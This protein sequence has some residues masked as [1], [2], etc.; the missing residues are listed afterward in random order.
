MITVVLIV[1]RESGFV[2]FIAM[3]IQRFITRAI[4]GSYKGPGVFVHYWDGCY[5]EDLDPYLT[6]K[7][8]FWIYT[9]DSENEDS[10]T[11]PD[12]DSEDGLAW[13]FTPV[14]MFAKG[15]PIGRDYFENRS[16]FIGMGN[17]FTFNDVL[18]EFPNQIPK[19]APRLERIDRSVI[20]RICPW[21]GMTAVRRYNFHREDFFEISEEPYELE[22]VNPV[23]WTDGAWS[24]GGYDEDNT[25]VLGNQ[26]GDCVVCCPACQALF[27]ASDVEPKSG[28]HDSSQN[29]AL[30]FVAPG[31]YS[32]GHFRGSLSEDWILTAQLDQ[33]MDYLEQSLA[34]G[35]LIE[36]SHWTAAQQVVNFISHHLRTG[37][38]LT[39]DPDEKARTLIQDVVHRTK[40]VYEGTLG[41]MYPHNNVFEESKEE[42]FW[43]HTFALEEGLPLANMRRIARDWHE[44]EVTLGENYTG[45]EDLQ[46]LERTGWS[47][48][49]QYILRRR[50][51]LRDLI[52]K[53]DSSWAVHSGGASNGGN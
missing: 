4:P 29:S 41:S 22:M 47:E 17:E 35:K 44:I 19:P 31:G 10:Q 13:E 8:E 51:L 46:G 27:L 20:H 26:Y 18:E 1:S 11:D 42:N 28:A 38:T 48:L 39:S 15:Q 45:I 16:K 40:Q 49:D 36:W 23:V 32:K 33:S 43:E 25:A 24:D 53:R 14:Q 21:C 2:D 12:F 50:L 6:E 5:E 3:P 9:T 37:G 34:T 52:A 30:H 7:Y